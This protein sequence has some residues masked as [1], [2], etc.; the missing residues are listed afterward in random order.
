MGFGCDGSDMSKLS[1]HHH[2]PTRSEVENI[3]QFF[4][5]LPHVLLC[6]VAAGGALFYS[7]VN[8]SIA[9][10]FQNCPL[11]GRCGI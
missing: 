4:I 3:S 2:G 5:L 7:T 1:V 9:R 11:C 8:V 6:S 10:T